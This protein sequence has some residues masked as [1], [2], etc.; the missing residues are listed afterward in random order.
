[1]EE[2]Y[3]NCNGCKGGNYENMEITHVDI[4]GMLLEN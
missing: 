4:S 2:N 1:M 3:K